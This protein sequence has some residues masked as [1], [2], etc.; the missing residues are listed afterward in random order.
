MAINPRER[1]YVRLDR[2]GRIITGS[3][4]R[5]NRMPRNGHW[6]EITEVEC[7]SYQGTITANDF[8]IATGTALTY[9]GNIIALSGADSTSSTVYSVSQAISDGTFTINIAS[10]G[11]ITITVDDDADHSVVYN[12]TFFDKTGNQITVHMTVAHTGS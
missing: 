12:V 2:S 5:R 4:V 10:D 9:T 6:R 8:T 3:V 7:C 11:A 1:V